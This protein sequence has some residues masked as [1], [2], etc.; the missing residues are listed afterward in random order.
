M[1]YLRLFVLAA[2]LVA[3]SAARAQQPA[4]P[5]P[6][7]STEV[8]SRNADSVMVTVVLKHQKDKN[9][10]EIRRI[11]EKQ[12]FWD[13]FPPEDAQVL[14]WNIAMGLGHV[15]TLVIPAGSVRFLNVAIE[16]AAW[17][18]FD[19]EIYLSYDYLGIWQDYMTRRTDARS[20]RD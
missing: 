18:A 4:K 12:G 7:P 13:V 20:D 11:L 19:T 1:P 14:S 6:G 16:N 8:P 15:I 10:P 9:L 17:G 2:L 5:G 3:G